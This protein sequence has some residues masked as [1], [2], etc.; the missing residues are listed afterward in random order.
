MENRVFMNVSN[1]SLDQRMPVA[2]H[3]RGF[4]VPLSLRQFSQLKGVIAWRPNFNL[5]TVEWTGT[6]REEDGQERNGGENDYPKD[7]E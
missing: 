2:V 5:V 4:P 6:R 1:V 3:C 7:R